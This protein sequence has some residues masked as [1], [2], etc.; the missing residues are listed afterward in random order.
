M[1]YLTDLVTARNNAA[2]ALAAASMRT[3][4]PENI[5]KLRETIKELNALIDDAAL[6]DETTG[7]LTPFEIETQ[8]VT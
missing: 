6:R 1:A 2:A 8:D 5:A 3:D 7:Q 4:S